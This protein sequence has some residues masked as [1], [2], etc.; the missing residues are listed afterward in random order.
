MVLRSLRDRLAKFNV[1]VAETGQQDV[2]NR[3]EITVAYVCTSRAQAD[4]IE[5][6]LDAFIDRV[7][8]L[9]ILDSRRHS[10]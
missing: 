10:L 7:R 2:W 9:V 8:D 4:S 3:S 5:E 6:K 1:S